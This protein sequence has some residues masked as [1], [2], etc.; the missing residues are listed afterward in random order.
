MS[1]LST[2]ID[3]S[4][5][6]EGFARP[7][8]PRQGKP[9]VPWARR[10]WRSRRT[11]TPWAAMMHSDLW[12]SGL[13]ERA[14]CGGHVL[15][16]IS[17]EKEAPTDTSKT[18]SG[19]LF[20]YTVLLTEGIASFLADVAPS[21]HS[22]RAVRWFFVAPAVVALSMITNLTPCSKWSIGSAY[23]I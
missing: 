10:C 12:F 23:F 21:L 4:C 6:A 3:S 14:Q 11:A 19:S 9:S 17:S 2:G 16:A 1:I 13:A 22:E 18:N 20:V 15:Q 8:L 5:W 7:L